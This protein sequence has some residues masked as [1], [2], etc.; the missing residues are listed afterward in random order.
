LEVVSI[1]NKKLA[2][3]NFFYMLQKIQDAGYVV[4]WRE[5][6]PRE[7]GCPQS[8][9]R[10][11]I[12]YLHVVK[13]GSQE[14]W[15]SGMSIQ[16]QRAQTLVDEAIALSKTFSNQGPRYR[17]EDFVFE[18]ND[19]L[20][21]EAWREAT[22]VAAT[23]TFKVPRRAEEWLTDHKAA[24]EEVG[25]YFVQPSNNAKTKA[26]ASKNPFFGQQTD[27]VKDLLMFVSEMHSN[28]GCCEAS[29]WQ[30]FFHVN[31]YS[32]FY[33]LRGASSLHAQHFVTRV[34]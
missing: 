8:R 20:V 16:R 5:A 27:R 19:L 18:P 25:L 7:S 1:K 26:R 11:Y 22:R 17:L 9:P 15:T 3:D 33:L 31:P 2:K 29:H 24:W 4:A 13:Y 34:P 10:L 23:K 12:I 30:V 6:D 21:Q 28:K 32:L 14:G